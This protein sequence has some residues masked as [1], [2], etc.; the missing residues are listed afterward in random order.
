[1][2]TPVLSP[3]LSFPPELLLKAQGIR[4]AIFDVDGVL[5]DGRIYIGA[6]GEE[7]KAF[8]TLDGHGLKL[9]AQGGIEPIVITGRDSPAVRRR[10]ADLGIRHAV[11]GAH[12]KLAAAH[13]VMATLQVDWSQLAAI[14]DDWP[15]LPLMTRVAFACAPANA[16]AEVLAVAHHVTTARGGYGAARECCDVLLTACGAYARLLH[17]HLTTLD[18]SP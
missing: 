17:G 5:T 8:N 16:H 14:G 18:A 9:L 7:F 6:G 11:Y 15:D 12:D 10:V 1:M 3:V 13:G 2:P 4:A